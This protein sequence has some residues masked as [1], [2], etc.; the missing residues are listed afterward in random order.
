MGK[1]NN[2][3]SP[4]SFVQYKPKIQQTINTD[5]LAKS[6]PS[7]PHAEIDGQTVQ[8]YRSTN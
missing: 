5:I 2:L 6:T 8:N 3:N 7:K 1:F 4:S